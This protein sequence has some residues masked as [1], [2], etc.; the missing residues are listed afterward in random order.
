MTSSE[1]STAAARECPVD[2]TGHGTGRHRLSRAGLL[3][4]LDRPGDLFSGIGPNW[5][6]SIMGTGI[7]GVAAATLPVQVPGLHTFAVGIWLL[8]SFLLVTL[9][10]AW[11]VHWVRHTGTALGHARNPVMAQFWGAVAMGVMTVGAG[12]VKFGGPFLGATGAIGAGWTL[13]GIGTVLGLVTAAWIPYMMIVHHRIEQGSAF[14]GWLMPVVPPMV[15]AANGALLVPHT[16]AGWQTSMV[17]ACYAMFGISLF[18]TLAILPQVW[19]RLVVHG[20]GP[21]ATVPTMWIV[22]GPLG[23][24]VTAANLLGDQAGVL[25]E[26]Y[27]TGAHVFGIFYGVPAWGFAMIWLVIAAA[28]TVRTARQKLPFALTWW[29]FTFPVG[30]C[31]TGTSAL[32]AHLH[33]PLLAVTAT[34]LYVM[35]VVAWAVVS[36]R[37]AHGS[38]VRGYLFAPA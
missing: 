25:G 31:V 9:T 30:T 37:T 1:L 15:S 24:S 13:W 5:Y 8:A 3:R 4:D 36:V 2:T 27:A 18:A 28:V 29:S 14:G 16:P 12:A 6:S 23:Q 10:A 21:A 26:P 17:V 19:N 35:L 32:A 22:L 33:L 11:A 7:V 38:L 34:A 20:T